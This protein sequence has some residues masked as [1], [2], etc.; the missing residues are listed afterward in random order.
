MDVLRT[1][2]LYLSKK[3]IWFLAMELKILGRMIDSSSIRMD[4]EKVN[5]VLAWKIPTNQDLLRGFIVRWGTWR[6][7]FPMSACLWVCSV[8]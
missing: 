1:E 2:K 5:G 7:T 3:K 6:M 4:P 8:L